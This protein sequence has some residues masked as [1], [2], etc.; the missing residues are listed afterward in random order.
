MLCGGSLVIP[1][2]VLEVPYQCLNGVSYD[3]IGL[4][5]RGVVMKIVWV[6]PF[7]VIMGRVD[8]YHAS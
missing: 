8:V 4:L 7:S 5:W 3:K 6:P 1:L 2:L